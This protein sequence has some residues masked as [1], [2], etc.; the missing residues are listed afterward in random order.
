MQ[1]YDCA[2]VRNIVPLKTT[3]REGAQGARAL[4]SSSPEPPDMRVR[5]KGTVKFALPP[6]L[7]LI[8]F[9]FWTA[10]L[11]KVGSITGTKVC[12]PCKRLVSKLAVGAGSIYASGHFLFLKVLLG[13]VT[14]PDPAIFVSY[15]CSFRNRSYLHKLCL[16]TMCQFALPRILDHLSWSLDLSFACRSSREEPCS[17]GRSFLS[18]YAERFASDF[19]MR[20]SISRISGFAWPSV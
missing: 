15:L 16:C 18:T 7:V 13:H 10:G 9:C 3:F 6:L 5:T 20:S 14:Y 1:V 17:G 4:F 2:I 8:V 19:M 12:V 11:S